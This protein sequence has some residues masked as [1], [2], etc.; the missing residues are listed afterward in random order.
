MLL[1]NPKGPTRHLNDSSRASTL[2][3]LPTKKARKSYEEGANTVFSRE[4]NWAR[5]QG[6]ARGA[7]GAREN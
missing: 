5:A 6:I 7:R 2:K 3:N 4:M 1:G